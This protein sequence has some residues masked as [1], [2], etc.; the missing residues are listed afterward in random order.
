VTSDAD[1]VAAALVATTTGPGTSTRAHRAFHPAAARTIGS[2]LGQ[3]PTHGRR[4]TDS[5]VDALLEPHAIRA[6]YQPLVR[7]VDGAI[8]GYEALARTDVVGGSPEQWLAEA[9]VS[10]RRIDVEIA[11]LEAALVGG[12]P[13]GSALLFV[14]VSP[15]TVLSPR[16]A[17]LVERLPRHVLEITEDAAVLDYEPLRAVL[18]DM[19]AAGS[20]VAVDDVGSGYASMAHVLQLSP[21]FV[22]ID[23]SLVTNVQRDPGRYALVRALQAFA[24]A[25]GAI[26]VAEGVETPQELRALRNLGVDLVQGYLLARPELPW[27][28]L[29]REAHR[30]LLPSAAVPEA[31]ELAE[32]GAALAATE[33]RDEA[34]EAVGGY[35][36]GL[37]GLL[38]SIYLDQGG[39]LR[40]HSRRGQW[41]VM[42]G[43]QPGTG[44]TGTAFLE[45]REILVENVALDTRYRLAVP[46]V[47]SE[48]AVPLQIDGQ[49]IGVCNVDSVVPLSAERC[50]LVRGA[51]RMLAH[52]LTD[53]PAGQDCGTALFDLSRLATRLALPQTP[54]QLEAATVDTLIDLTGFD[55]GCLWHLG[56]EPTAK[57][58]AG[59][60][61]AGLAELPHP[62]VL[63]FADLVAPLTSCYSGGTDLSLAVPAT[64]ALRAL[65]AR[66]AIMLPLRQGRDLTDVLVLTSSTVSALEPGTVV[67]AENLSVQVGGRLT[68]LRRVAELEQ[69]IGRRP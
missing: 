53:L 19:R 59:P 11:C 6:V 35:L 7:L 46:G 52:R 10:G 31:A 47:H 25:I 21:S 28:P 27:T 45:Q 68:A 13:P 60:R 64:S 58:F 56:G 49:V 23:K 36:A 63:G 8:I 24:A 48:L 14:N 20:L 22:K 12:P 43:L 33:S 5:L 30:L 2:A 67:A 32:L 34:C 40:C 37:G 41:L 4:V 3:V 62:D 16:F 65:G 51:A 66:G 9:D 38:P 61:G 57:A 18:R 29:T 42:E 1:G 54:E 69:L 55:S 44:I 26:T 50:A 17:R 15:E 39:S